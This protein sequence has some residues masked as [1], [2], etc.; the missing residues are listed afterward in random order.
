MK[1][2]LGVVGMVVGTIGIVLSLAMIVVVWM[3][4]GVVNEELASFIA[5]IDR[6]LERAE[7]ALGEVEGRLQKM[8]GG[9][10]QVNATAERL[11]Q[12]HP[13]DP[14][15]ADA[16]VD[17]IERTLGDEYVAIREAYVTVRERTVAA[18]E[19]IEQLSLRF[20]R[21]PVPQL[22]VE[23]LEAIDERLRELDALLRNLRSV[24]G[25]VQVPGSE[26]MQRIGTVTQQIETRIGTLASRVNGLESRLDQGQMTLAR[27]QSTL[28]GWVTQVAIALTGI[29]LYSALLHL[30]LVLLSRYWAWPPRPAAE[31]DDATHVLVP[32]A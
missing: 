18:L 32:D 5:P 14:R 21:L 24:I 13:V 1:R 2:V 28:E 27:T 3:G 26:L 16:M 9:V 12:T 31:A 17:V 30:S 8:Q 15:V 4:R 20:P 6:G 11:G 29:C 19:R 23:E 7:T 22:P 10:A 25:S